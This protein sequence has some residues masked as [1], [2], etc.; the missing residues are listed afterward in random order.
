MKFASHVLIETLLVA[1]MHL[2]FFG[3]FM[4][5]V[6][7]NFLYAKGSSNCEALALLHAL[8]FALISCLMLFIFFCILKE[9]AF[10]KHVASCMLLW[11]ALISCQS[12]LQVKYRNST[13]FDFHEN[14][15]FATK[16]VQLQISGVLLTELLGR[17]ELLEKEIRDLKNSSVLPVFKLGNWTEST[18][19]S[20]AGPEWIVCANYSGKGILLLVQAYAGDSVADNILRITLDGT[21]WREYV[22]ESFTSGIVD[23]W[24]L[25]DNN[26]DDN[27]A[28]IGL[29]PF[30]TFAANMT[31]EVYNA[32][33]SVSEAVC[34]VNYMKY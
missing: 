19:Y 7:Y 1:H 25:A 10:V 30:K 14:G 32:G 11:F 5:D 24:D 26:V 6:V 2:L 18:A 22:G 28:T 21:I 34:R 3:W 13:V 9:A 27:M 12:N 31:T 29:T 33:T 8:W 17:I 4:P 16:D 15:T 23:E 20:V